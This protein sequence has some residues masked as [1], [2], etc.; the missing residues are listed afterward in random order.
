M[1]EG[2][3]A[4]TFTPEPLD[5]LEEPHGYALEIFLLGFGRPD[6]S[7]LGEGQEW[8]ECCRGGGLGESS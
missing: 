6:A 2:E 1:G 3:G 7:G 4:H 8:R 5:V